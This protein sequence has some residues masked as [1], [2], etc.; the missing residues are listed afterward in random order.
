MCVNWG[1]R[2]VVYI[3]VVI[4]FIYVKLYHVGIIR[5][6]NCHGKFF[7]IWQ[8]QRHGKCL[9]SKLKQVE[10]SAQVRSCPLL[11]HGKM[12]EWDELVKLLN[13]SKPER[14]FML[15]FWWHDIKKKTIFYIYSTC[16]RFV[17]KFWDGKPKYLLKL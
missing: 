1:M 5:R 14:I 11:T 16:E 6:P 17:N 10:R 12:C 13:W 2:I 4:R 7:W 3:S 9:A 15:I 8:E